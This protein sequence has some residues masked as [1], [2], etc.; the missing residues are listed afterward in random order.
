MERFI[1]RDLF[2]NVRPTFLLLKRKNKT[3]AHF[4]ILPS[5]KKKKSFVEGQGDREKRILCIRACRNQ[6]KGQGS[7]S[8]IHNKDLQPSSQ[9]MAS[10]MYHV[11]S[12]LHEFNLLRCI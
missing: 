8:S 9:S 1:S 6:S 12:Y 4:E 7:S 5:E 2:A 11:L 3:H 10:G